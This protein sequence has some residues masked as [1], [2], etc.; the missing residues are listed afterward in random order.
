[1]SKYVAVYHSE[2]DSLRDL[3][4]AAFDAAMEPNP[5]RG[6]PTKS[7]KGKQGP[8]RPRTLARGERRA[9]LYPTGAD[10]LIWLQ[11]KR[12][13]N[14]LHGYSWPGLRKL[15]ELTGLSRSTVKRSLIA[16]EDYRLVR[17][18]HKWG[19][20]NQYHRWACVCDACE[21]HREKW[22]TLETL[23]NL[24]AIGGGQ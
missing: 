14:R 21:D 12:Y 7:G 23:D 8:F 18:I 22:D 15:Q 9:A 1:M 16:L 17:V 5:D 20:G 4:L 2:L 19:L 24:V 3:N 6:K 11:I 10:I 13:Y